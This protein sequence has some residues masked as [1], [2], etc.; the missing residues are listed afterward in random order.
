MPILLHG[1]FNFILMSRIPQL[2]M[3]FVPYV[4]Y[5]WWINQRKLSKFLYDS[6]S[7]VIDIRRE[8]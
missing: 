5:I 3:L 8:E 6:R 1:T 7:R 4:I 2:T